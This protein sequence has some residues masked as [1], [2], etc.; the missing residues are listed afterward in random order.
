MQCRHKSAQSFHH[1]ISSIYKQK[2][3]CIRRMTRKQALFP[4]GTKR[5]A[6]LSWYLMAQMCGRKS[7]PKIEKSFIVSTVDFV[8][9]PRRDWS[10][11]HAAF[12][13]CLVRSLLF[14]IWK[15]GNLEKNMTPDIDFNSFSCR[16]S[17]YTAFSCRIWVNFQP[18]SRFKWTSWS[19]LQ[20][21]HVL[22]KTLRNGRVSWIQDI[23]LPF[24]LSSVSCEPK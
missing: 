19:V 8:L 6:V 23:Q 11:R 1:F 2:E 5:M 17:S 15:T 20:K 13:T 14:S 10:C 7:D 21:L 24:R 22:N 16:P 4:H 12:V 9:N 3:D 18:G